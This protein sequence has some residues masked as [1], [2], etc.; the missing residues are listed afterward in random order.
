ML[1][2]VST[3]LTLDAAKSSNRPAWSARQSSR[4]K[5]I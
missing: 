4:M 5:K 1:D 3:G 2:I